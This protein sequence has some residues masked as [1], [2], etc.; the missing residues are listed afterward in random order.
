MS[1][2]LFFF[3]IVDASFYISTSSFK[4]LKMFLFKHFI[5][6]NVFRI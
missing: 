3:E 1:A 4:M 6:L 2:K 5:W